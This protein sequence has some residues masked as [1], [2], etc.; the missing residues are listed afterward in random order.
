M[1]ILD[2]DMDFFQTE[3]NSFDDDSLIHWNND[4]VEIWDKDRFIS[5]LELQCGLSKKERIK[6]RIFNFHKN[7][8]Y[9]IQDLIESGRVQPPISITHIDAHSDM[10]FDTSIRYYRFLKTLNKDNNADFERKTLFDGKNH[11]YINS[12]NY[13]VALA[14]NAWVDEITYVYHETTTML[15]FSENYIRCVVPREEFEFNFFGE[16]NIPWTKIK[17]KSGREYKN[18]GKYDYICVAISP[19]YTIRDIAKLVDIL[20]DYIDIEE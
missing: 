3:I 16:T 8:Y 15:D 11:E 13:L 2:I 17:V 7:T 9:V 5:F 6:G 20:K 10:A 4:C 19:S 1:R 14:L 18:N 12:G